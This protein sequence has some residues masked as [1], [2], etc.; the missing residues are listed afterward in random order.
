MNVI[1]AGTP[2]FAAGFLDA[3]IASEHE[4]RAVVTRSDRPGKRGKALVPGPVKLRAQRVGLK[5]LQ[6]DRL[7]ADDIKTIACDLMVVVA[8]G[9]ILKQDLLDYPRL[10]CI[11]VH[12]SALPRWRGA[13]PVQRA[14]L[15]GDR[16]TGVTLIQMDAGL[17][18]GDI[19][20]RAPV[21]IGPKDSSGDLF[22]KLGQ[23]GQP[24]LIQ[25]LHQLAAGKITPEPQ[26]DDDAVYARKIDKR[27]ALLDWSAGAAQIDRAVRAFHPEPVAYTWLGDKRVRIHEGEPVPGAG[28]GAGLILEVSRAGLL[29]GC[30]DSAYRVKRIQLPLGKGSV[31]N[32][33]DLVNGR[34]RLLSVGQGFSAS[35]VDPH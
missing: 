35:P 22:R 19:L 4:V 11:N 10:G 28:G 14:I 3:L 21:P 25:T 8:Y 12:A 7:A 1:F 13:A 27:E 6:P 23:A 30:G 26:K 34:T 5:V 18:T 9:Q 31:L 20:A 15:A 17:D 29:V 2:A 16:A 33:A 32:G 24:L